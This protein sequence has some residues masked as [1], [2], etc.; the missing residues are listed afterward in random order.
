VLIVIPL[1][2]SPIS[3]ILLIYFNVERDPHV[4]LFRSS[5]ECCRRHRMP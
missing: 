3:T 1:R 2:K 4:T 5:N